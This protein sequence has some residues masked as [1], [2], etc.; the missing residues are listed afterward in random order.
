MSEQISESEMIAQIKEKFK[1]TYA[2]IIFR[3]SDTIEQMK[4]QAA[5]KDREIAALKNNIKFLKAQIDDQ[6][7]PTT[8][9]YEDG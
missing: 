6:V 3:I 7:E 8:N 1:N 9:K 5:A 4:I 2:N